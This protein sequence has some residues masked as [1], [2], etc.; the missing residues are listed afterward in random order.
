MKTAAFAAV[1]FFIE[2]TERSVHRMKQNCEV[3]GALPMARSDKKNIKGKNQIRGILYGGLFAFVM[4]LAFLLV[5]S[6]AILNGWFRPEAGEKLAVA[7]CAAGGFL[8][9]L[10]V[11]RSVH[12]KALG[13]GFL[14]GFTQF[15]LFMLFGLLTLERMTP[16][17]GQLPLLAACLCSA[18]LAGLLSGKR[19]KRRRN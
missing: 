9:P 19:K 8:G 18:G 16:G 3:G 15:I 14:V 10:F 13:I 6:F 4:S 12:A 2:W 11:V 5:L 17:P 1:F 7:A